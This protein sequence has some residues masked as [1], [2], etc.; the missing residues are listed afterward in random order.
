MCFSLFHLCPTF[1]QHEGGDYLQSEYCGPL[2]SG[3][4]G[5]GH[6]KGL[7]ISN[8]KERRRTQPI[9]AAYTALR[10]LPRY[11]YIY[12]IPIYFT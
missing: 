12:L 10:W 1:S 11:L 5:P 9:N 7:P 8:K 6:R 2:R 4:P 3:L